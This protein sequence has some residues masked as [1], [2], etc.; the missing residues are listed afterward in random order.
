MDTQV[1]TPATVEVE[2]AVN[3][4]LAAERD[5]AQAVERCRREAQVLVEQGRQRAR[6]VLDRAEARIARAHATSDRSLEMRLAEIRAASASLAGRPLVEE[7][8]LARVQDAVPR[9]AAELSSG[10]A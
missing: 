4:V 6:R 1:S 9:L 3:R 7:A 10:G 5:A 8:D 2:L